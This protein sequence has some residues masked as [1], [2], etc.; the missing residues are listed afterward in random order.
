[1]FSSFC[2]EPK[3]YQNRLN[4]FLRFEVKCC[5]CESN[6][7]DLESVRF[8]VCGH[9]TFFRIGFNEKGREENP[10]II[11]AMHYNVLSK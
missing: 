9:K 6:Y 2:L 3:H 11:Q 8:C 7:R 10:I 1:M 4:G 5:S